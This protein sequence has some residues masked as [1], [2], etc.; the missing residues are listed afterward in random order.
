[1]KD[2]SEATKAITPQTMT[3]ALV[4]FEPVPRLEATSIVKD[5]G[6]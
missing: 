2:I 4:S 1:M 5:S 6:R 3:V